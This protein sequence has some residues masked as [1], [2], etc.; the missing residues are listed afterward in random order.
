[1][2]IRIPVTQEYLADVLAAQAR[3][4]KVNHP[5]LEQFPNALY[6]NMNRLVHKIAHKYKGTIQEQEDELAQNCFYHL[7]KR[8]GKFDSTRGKFTTFAWWAC[9]NHMKSCYGVRKLEKEHF[10]SVHEDSEN[11]EGS[12]ITCEFN[13]YTHASD[14][15]LRYEI[16]DTIRELITMYPLKKEL[17]ISILGNPTDFENRK[18]KDEIK[19][20]QIVGFSRKE[21]EKFYHKTIVPFFKTRFGGVK[22]V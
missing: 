9:S 3:G 22:H 14:S 1:M 21:K 13:R 17:T 11:Q 5:A 4:E 20:N 16:A 15:M 18:F 19:L 8:L 6:E 2:V 10:V 12:E 7:W